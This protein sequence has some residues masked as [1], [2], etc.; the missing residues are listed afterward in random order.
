MSSIFSH[1]KLKTFDQCGW[2]FRLEYLDR[3]RLPDES[4]EIYVGHRVHES[5]EAVYRGLIERRE[6]P[7]LDAVL[8]DY[9]AAWDRHWHEAIYIVRAG[10]QA[11]TYRA[12]GER[13]LR[14]Y[15]SAHAPFDPATE[16]TVAVEHELRFPVDATRGWMMRCIMDRVVRR[17]DGVWE[18]HDY[19]T[20]A[21]LPR[22]SEFDS[23]EGESTGRQLALY[24]MILQSVHPDAVR[25][26]LKWHYLAHNKVMT[27]TRTPERI[28][29]L[30]RSVLAAIERVEAAM[31][32]PETL[33]PKESALCAW[34]QYAG[35]C[36]AKKH[37]FQVRQ[38]PAEQRRADFGVRLVDGYV[39]G[40]AAGSHGTAAETTYR[41]RLLRYAEHHSVFVLEGTT[42]R[43]RIRG[44]VVV[45]EEVKGLDR[46][47]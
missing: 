30:H 14:D 43:A 7:L 38:M 16:Y 2:K 22:Q 21:S 25:V 47:C 19:K 12:N 23:D 45:L 1:S 9:H 13:F 36:P 27:S 46:R 6:P 18:I 3:L 37:I 10:M 42:K 28:A 4:I 34:C 35:H 8:A 11:A 41:Q 29:A 32:S 26:E 17:P 5:L 24:Q 33:A 40:M 20:A 39:L 31:A 15:F 44:D